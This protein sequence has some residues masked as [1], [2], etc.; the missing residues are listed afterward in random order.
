ASAA[1]QLENILKEDQSAAFIFEP[2]VQGVAGMVMHEPEALETL[3]KL[4]KTYNVLCIADEVMTGFAR[5]G[6]MFATDYLQIS[7]DIVCLSNGITGGTMSFSV[8]SCTEE[9][10]LAFWSDDRRKTFW[11]GHSYTANPVACAAALAS[12]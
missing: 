7:P 5:T 9:F 8:T 1:E 11:H 4:C 10:Y 3:L 6:K 2:L 12:L